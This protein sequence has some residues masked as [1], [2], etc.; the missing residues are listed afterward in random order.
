[1][2]STNS[3]S[4]LQMVLDQSGVGYWDWNIQKGVG[5]ISNTYKS[6]LGYNSLEL[7]DDTNYVQLA[8]L[9]F[10]EDYKRALELLQTHIN[11]KATMPF[12]TE[13]RYHHKSGATIWVNSRANVVEWDEKGSAIRIVGS[14]VDI[15]RQKEKEEQ[16]I[17]TN[18]L[19]KILSHINTFL[20]NTSTKQELYDEVC[21]IINIVGGIKL[22]WI[23]EVDNNKV[24]S[25]SKAGAPLSY[26][27]NINISLDDSPTG[28]GPTARAIKENK[29]YICNDYFADANT[30][31]WQNAA[32]EAGIKSAATFPLTYNGKNIGCLTVYS[33]FKNYF[34]EKEVALF[35]EIVSAIFNGIERLKLASQKKKADNRI[36]LL[37]DIIDKSQALI[38][39]AKV[40]D[41]TFIYLNNAFKETL[42]LSPDEDVS[43][44][45]VFDVRPSAQHD[46]VENT[47][48]TEVKKNG[49]WSGSTQILN[50]SGKIIPVFQTIT[51]FDDG[52]SDKSLFM[53]STA[54]NIS[55]LKEKEAELH[56]LT[57]HLFTVREDERKSI[58]K[59]IHDELGQNLTGLKLGISWLKKHLED[60]KEVLLK[61]LEEIDSITTDT[62]TATRSLYNSLYP[63]MLEDVGL[64]GSIRWHYKTYLTPNNIEVELNT[65]LKEEKPVFAKDT[66]ACLAVYR[67]YQE[68]TTNILRYAKATKVT[69]G[70][71]VEDGFLHLQIKD[72]GIGF[73]ID[74]VDTKLHHGLIGMKERIKSLKGTLLLHSAPGKGTCKVVKVPIQ[75]VS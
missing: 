18:N 10:E 28:S 49:K 44:I 46:F 17:H 48:L 57:T 7:S 1:M 29:N 52:S 74:K 14:I 30:F 54:I 66:N 45:S 21:N 36:K 60:D 73:D 5:K 6:I 32:R 47:I 72:N 63:Q 67:V 19:N 38:A 70:L 20:L 41:N 68:C 51:I 64:L 59:E 35:E 31:P 40:S 55:E 24:T 8:K 53:T 26:L 34:K 61:K 22:V 43:K 11:S 3:D 62:V 13:L 9:I 33:D 39:I 27:E 50:R 37:A 25:I 69:I 56:S 4:L 23:G 42:E 65:N 75:A 12:D 71:N 15:T 16:L 2:S 58:A